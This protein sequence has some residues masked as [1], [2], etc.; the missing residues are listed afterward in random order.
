M[1]IFNGIDISRV[2]NALVHPFANSGRDDIDSHKRKPFPTMQR[3]F[4]QPLCNSHKQLSRTWFFLTS[5][6]PWIIWRQMNDLVFNG[7]Q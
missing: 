7:L 4:E 5:G 2:V 6:L 1:V 3:L